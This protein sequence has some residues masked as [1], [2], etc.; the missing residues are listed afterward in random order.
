MEDLIGSLSNGTLAYQL[1]AMAELPLAAVV[2]EGRYPKL[3]E[4]PRARDGWLPDVLARLQIRLPRD[5]DRICGFAQVRRMNGRT[6]SSR[7]RSPISVLC[8]IP[9]RRSRRDRDTSSPSGELHEPQGGGLGPT[10]SDP[11]CS[12]ASIGEQSSPQETAAGT[13]ATAAGR[14]RSARYCPHELQRRDTRGARRVARASDELLGRI[15]THAARARTR[16]RRFPQPTSF[17]QPSRKSPRPPR[18]PAPSLRWHSSARAAF[19]DP[20]FTFTCAGISRSAWCRSPLKARRLHP[21][22]WTSTTSTRTVA[23]GFGTPSPD[24]IPF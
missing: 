13:R 15:G 22:S 5:P 1:A 19:S 8:Q 3:F 24:D 18:R 6:G 2:V 11:P 12:L 7:R 21:H 23:M 10:R 9:A 4:L 17:V 14:P 16:G 20:A